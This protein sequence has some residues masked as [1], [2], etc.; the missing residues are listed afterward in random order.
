MDILKFKIISKKN[1]N[2]LIDELEKSKE[3]ISSKQKSIENYK[4]NYEILRIFS[5][6]LMKKILLNIGVRQKKYPL[7]VILK[8]IELKKRGKENEILQKKH[9]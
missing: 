7:G 4:R 2:K 8:N 9:W 3:K 6:Y 1:Y 5:T